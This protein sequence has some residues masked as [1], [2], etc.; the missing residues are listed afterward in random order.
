MHVDD[1][2][3]DPFGGTRHSLGRMI[4]DRAEHLAHLDLHLR[5][6]LHVLENQQAPILEQLAQLRADSL[7]ANVVPSQAIDARAE[8]ESGAKI[9]DL[10]T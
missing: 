7:V 8:G 6:W 1:A 4:L 5:A 2:G 9:T 10:Q 3:F